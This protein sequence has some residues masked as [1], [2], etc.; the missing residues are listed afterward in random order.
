VLQDLSFSHLA[1]DP[2]R[3][4]FVDREC[5]RRFVRQI[6]PKR[7]AQLKTSL[8]VAAT[9]YVVFGATDIATLGLTATAWALLALRV[10]VALV[11]LGCYAAICRRPQSVTVSVGASS[12]LLVAALAAF[13]VVSWYQPQALPWN[14]MTQALIV[15]AVYVNFPNRF[16]YAVAIG[17]GSSIVFGMMLWT[18]GLLKADGLLTLVFLLILANALGYIASWRVHLAQREEYRAS[19]LLQQMAERDA[20]TGCFNRRILQKG[21]LDAELVRARRYGTP[22]SVVL[23][24]IDHFKRIND[25]HGHGAGDQVLGDFAG[26]LRAMTRETVD[27][28]IRYGGE[29]FLLVLPQTDAAGAQALAERMRLAFD[30]AATPV[31]DG[32]SVSATASFG[33]ASI[34]A[35][36]ASYPASAEELIAA[37]DAELYA[38][39]HGGRNGVRGTVLC[40]RPELLRSGT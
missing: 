32:K 1:I 11:A 23:C 26:L 34:P 40:A 12:T 6:L 17:V 9:A 28:V 14:A 3:A 31:G 24:D 10:L 36:H 8:L 18:Q 16:A 39:K 27:S 33:I 37:A 35:R 19:I 29:E 4:E 25:T 5:E 21:L 7:N 2:R 38:V 22:L 30:R 15:M 13:M 20:L